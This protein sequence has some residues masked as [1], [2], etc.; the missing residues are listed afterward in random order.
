VFSDKVIRHSMRSCI[1]RMI[2]EKIRNGLASKI[3]WIAPIL[4]VSRIGK[5]NDILVTCRSSNDNSNYD[6][7]INTRVFIMPHRGIHLHRCVRKKNSIKDE[8]SI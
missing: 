4:V 2:R 8:E 7:Y 1:I 5:T 6:S 3:C